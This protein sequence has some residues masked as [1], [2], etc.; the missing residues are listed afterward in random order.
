MKT[1]KKIA[2]GLIVLVAVLGL[3]ELGIPVN[4]LDRQLI[5][6]A[7]E[8]EPAKVQQLLKQGANVDS[9]DLRGRT[10]LLAA[11]E[12]NH[13][14]VARLLIEAGADVNVQDRILDSPLLLAGA[15]GT[16]E[17]LQM[18]LKAGPDFSLYNR[19]GG[20][21]LIPACERGHV[22]V[23]KTLLATEVDVDHVNH[24]GWTALLEAIL[25][26]DGGPR[27]QE[28]VRLLV[29]AGA[30]V[31]IADSDGITP[32]QHARQK[33]YDDIVKILESADRRLQGQ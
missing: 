25:L 27:H 12:E 32:L 14:E 19:Y 13:I 15:S 31:T 9:Q 23:V 8:G 30:D 26:S 28:V 24:L 33:G 3:A 17:I 21:A 29:D 16:L 20:T 5:D 1:V 6:V 11:V 4:K 2:A 10:A 22:E 18:I 7:E